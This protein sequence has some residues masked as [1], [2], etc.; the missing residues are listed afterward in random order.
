MLITDEHPIVHY[1]SLMRAKLM[2]LPAGE[3]G[4]VEVAKRVRL[5][6]S[7]TCTCTGSFRFR[8]VTANFQGSE[9]RRLA[10]YWLNREMIGTSFSEP[11]PASF[12]FSLATTALEH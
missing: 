12:S 8:H 5:G 2:E 1:S 10:V 11:N 7:C 6:R 4:A 3:E 9:N